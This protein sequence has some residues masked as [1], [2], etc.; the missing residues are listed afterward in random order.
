MIS[1]HPCAYVG[2]GEGGYLG[3]CV[4]TCMYV[5]LGCVFGWVEDNVV[6]GKQNERTAAS[7]ALFPCLT[8]DSLSSPLMATLLL[9]VFQGIWWERHVRESV[10]GG[11]GGGRQ[12]AG[13]PMF[14][15]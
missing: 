15:L 7:I 4:C 5:G 3:V 12:G 2:G 1:H 6:Y 11:R 9:V 10:P 14:L 8:E 13:P